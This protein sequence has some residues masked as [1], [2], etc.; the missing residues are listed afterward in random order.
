MNMDD[1]QARSAL[2]VEGDEWPHVGHPAGVD[3]DPHVHRRLLDRLAVADA[4]RRHIADALHDGPVQDLATVGIRLGTYRT[5]LS[6]D[7]ARQAIQEL[8]QGVR[9]ALSSIRELIV[10]LAPPEVD[11]DLEAPL[12]AYV[13]ETFGDEVACTIEV[14]GDP[15]GHPVAEAAFRILQQALSNIRAHAQARSLR[16]RVARDASAVVGEVVDDG[17]GAAP[18]VLMA[19]TPGHLG[20][21]RMH[22]HAEAVGGW[23]R[24]ASGGDGGVKVRFSLPLDGPTPA[25]GSS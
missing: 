18:E 3:P 13:D 17:V 22:E 8:E 10:D 2:V 16:V 21:R 23:V 9:H 6:D 11:D 12:R 14:E 1:A 25:E 24:L 20:L 19:S 7:R 4:E 15:L 5:S